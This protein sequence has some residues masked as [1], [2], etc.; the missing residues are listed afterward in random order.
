MEEIYSEVP[1]LPYMQPINRKLI[2]HDEEHHYAYECPINPQP[3]SNSHSPTQ[4][5]H[6]HKL[7]PECTLSN[8]P[9]N[10]KS[11]V[12]SLSFSLDF[13]PTFSDTICIMAFFFL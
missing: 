11:M 6:I 5:Y 3:N 9:I 4:A 12:S 1:P 10:P 8:T 2:T 7:P 13:S